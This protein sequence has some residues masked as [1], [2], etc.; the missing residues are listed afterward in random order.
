MSKR[1]E[2]RTY[3]T[4]FKKN[5][6]KLSHEPNRSVQS[7]TQGLGVPRESLYRWRVEFKN[8]GSLAFPGNGNEALTQDQKRIKELEKQLKE[9]EMDRDILKKAMDIFSR[10]SK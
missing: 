3:D 9:V 2:R 7:V 5:A 4:E 1:K 6:V 10:I 8:N